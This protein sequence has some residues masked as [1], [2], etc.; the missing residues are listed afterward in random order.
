MIGKAST[1]LARNDRNGVDAA[2][3][4]AG[5]Q[6]EHDPER[7]REQR[8]Q[9][10]NDEHDAAAGDDPAEYVARELVAAEQIGQAGV[11]TRSRPAARTSFP[12]SGRAD[13]KAD[14]SGENRRE[15]PEADQQQ[16]RESEAGF[17]HMPVE[18][19]PAAKDEAQ[20]PARPQGS[21][22]PEAADE[23]RENDLAGVQE[24]QA[25]PLL[26]A[27]AGIEIGVADIRDELGRQHQGHRNE[28]AG[29]QEID[30][31]VAGGVDQRLPKPW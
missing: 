11:R 26:H 15:Q 14:P 4:I 18:A 10:R 8:R 12:R 21:P 13:R 30:V 27:D 6:A 23:D 31:V 1:R 28:R 9:R 3:E 25:R 17:D 2:A 19:E 20:R 5:G 7:Q 24:L 16:T 22:R 29:E